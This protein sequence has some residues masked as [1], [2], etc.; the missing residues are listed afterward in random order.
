MHRQQ[1]QLLSTA[2]LSINAPLSMCKSSATNITQGTELCRCLFD[3]M[4]KDVLQQQQ[5]ED[6]G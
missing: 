5:G 1:L 4:F 6:A 3:D 2:D